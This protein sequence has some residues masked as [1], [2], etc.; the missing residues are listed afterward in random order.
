MFVGSYNKVQHAKP[1]RAHS[2][3]RCLTCARR[4]ELKGGSVW[5]SI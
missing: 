4:Y 2:L 3:P 5:Q 1:T